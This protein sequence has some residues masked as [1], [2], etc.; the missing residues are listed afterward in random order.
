MK[1][2]PGGF[3]QVRNISILQSRG[4]AVLSFAL[5]AVMVLLGFMLCPKGESVVEGFQI[6]AYVITLLAGVVIYMMLHEVIHGILMRFY[7]GARVH[8]RFRGVYA[9]AGCDGYFTK[10]QYVRIALAPV[11]ILGL[12]LGVLIWALY[13]KHFW[14]FYIL[15]ILNV[16][17]AAGDVY[18][19]GRIAR[20]PAGTMVQD[21]GTNMTFYSKY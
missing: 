3:R 21:T 12:G 10:G 18:I 8:Y 7:S 16:S 20:M 17:G 19:T 13:P 11:A 2:L 15:Q 9:S 4:M 14:Y 5:I 1:E 6:V